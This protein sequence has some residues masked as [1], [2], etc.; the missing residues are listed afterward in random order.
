VTKAGKAR[1]AV[2]A[3]MSVLALVTVLGNGAPYLSPTAFFVTFW[4]DAAAN[5]ASRSVLADL[6]WLGLA[7]AILM[8]V[9][10]RRHGVR[11]YWAYLVGGY[12]VAISVTFPL[13]L[14]ARERRIAAAE[15]QAAAKLVWKAG[16]G[17]CAAPGVTGTG[18]VE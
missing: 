10:G 9:E 13:F 15:R 4:R 18:S 7:A 14:I 16:F 6:L 11:F 1:C 12:F 3:A 5:G 17:G 2:Y 8:V